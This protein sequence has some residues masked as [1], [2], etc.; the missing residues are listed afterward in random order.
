V[1]NRV[2]AAS[3]NVGT[4]RVEICVWGMDLFQGQLLVSARA[5]P[6]MATDIPLRV[7]AVK[8]KWIALIS[9][10]SIVPSQRQMTARTVGYIM[11]A[12]RCPGWPNFTD[13]IRDNGA[14]GTTG[15]G[16]CCLRKNKETPDFILSMI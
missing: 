12:R 6:G 15:L 1:C 9:S 13:F 16:E 3:T 5:V 4:L 7:Q 11:V 8:K 2:V 14:F 10:R